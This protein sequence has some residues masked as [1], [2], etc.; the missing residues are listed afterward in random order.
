MY[1]ARF[2]TD[3]GEW[4]Q[5]IATTHTTASVGEAASQWWEELG[6]LLCRAVRDVPESTIAR[7]IS[8][9]ERRQ[10]HQ[11]VSVAA[12]VAQEQRVRYVF[13]VLTRL[14]R[15]R[16]GT[17][18]IPLSPKE[19]DQWSITASSLRFSTRDVALS[20]NGSPIIC[21]LRIFP[22]LDE[23]L[24]DAALRGAALSYQI[25]VRSVALDTEVVRAMRKATLVL[26]ARLG[27]SSQI[28]QWQDR[29]A[30]HAGLARAITEEFVMV[31]TPEA[32]R[33]IESVLRMR[34]ETQFEAFRFSV[35]DLTFQPQA[36]DEAVGVGV[37]SHELDALSPAA[38]CSAAMSS[39]EL[40]AA[41]MWKPSRR[42]QSLLPVASDE[43]YVNSDDLAAD[44]SAS[45]NVPVPY[46]GTEPFAFVSYKRGDFNVIA[47]VLRL[48]EEHGRNVWYD[49]GI[50]GGAE[51][52]AVI[53]ERVRRCQL[54]IVF[55]SNAAI[56]SK[57][58]RR[59][60]KFADALS[61][62]VL[63]IRLEDLQLSHGLGMLLTQY[64]MLNVSAPD[65]AER[66]GAA[67]RHLA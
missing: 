21:D 29:L 37:H 3:R 20:I 7:R 57:Y 49:R 60:V 67:L 59:E 65:F 12:P 45:L 54:L 24:A 32:A 11:M 50:P 62:P 30:R 40:E 39:T 19:H 27:A 47:P 56:A 55:V 17:I 22:V 28:V 46:E 66:L 13:G 8:L 25:H 6:R 36:H 2:D 15:I 52:D 10:L 1:I 38:L 26:E 41:L 33:A 18:D 23:L 53:E 4:L 58:V 31:D 34:F 16:G 43:G 63:S 64:Q 42:L 44:T 5:A 35:P 61:I 51:W 9:D 48:I 14:D